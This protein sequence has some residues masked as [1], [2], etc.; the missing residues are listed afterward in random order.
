MLQA[1][2]PTDLG[3]PPPGLSLARGSRGASDGAGPE[4]EPR[5]VTEDAFELQ[6]PRE[7]TCGLSARRWV[8]QQVGDQLSRGALDDVKLVV[9]ELVDN[10]YWHGR[11]N[12]WLRLRSVADSLRVEVI[13]EGTDAKVEIRQLG[14]RGGGHGLRLVDALSSAWGSSGVTTRVWAELPL[15]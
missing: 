13:D 12:I 7:P 5:T 10:A 9:S 11:G 2:P 3:H 8:E 1:C 14:V 4:T 6:L 15:A